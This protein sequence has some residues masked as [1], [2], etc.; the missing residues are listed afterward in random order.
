M[1]ESQGLVSV[2][3]LDVRVHRVTMAQCLETI[4]RFVR[5]GGSHHVV[6][7]D[8]SM[9]VMA[10][11]D[12]DLRRIVNQADLVTPDSTGVLWACRKLKQPLPERV[13]GVEIAEALC[14]SSSA[15]EGHSLYFLGAAPGIAERAAQKMREQ[16]PGCRIVGTRDGFFGPDDECA[17][18]REIREAAPD[19]LLVAFGIPKQEKWIDAHRPDLKVPVMIGVGGTFDVLSGSVKRAPQWIQRMNL[20]W[21]YRVIKNPRKIGKVGTLPRF[22]W[23]TVR[24]RK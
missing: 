7:L 20:E 24:S 6:T 13:S 2:P 8:S 17:M 5:E 21:L 22:V 15:P 18:L 1:V 12:A 14:A 19:I 16:Y 11:E 3:L 4:S 10:R 9:C 23:M